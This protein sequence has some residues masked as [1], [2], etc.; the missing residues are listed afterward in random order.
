MTSTV[1]RSP[2]LPERVRSRIT[3]SGRRRYVRE[4]R[5]FA[6]TADR[7]RDLLVDLLRYLKS[8]GHTIG[9]LGASTKGNTLLQ[10]CGLGP[11]LIEGIGEVNPNKVGRDTPGSNIPIVDE[12]EVLGCDY[13]LVLP[14]HF[15]SSFM[16][17]YAGYL[18][19]GGRL[20]FPLPDITTEVA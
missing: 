16:E 7:H 19:H 11:D 17:R 2:S 5:S 14:W 9:A 3:G 13:L 6:A 10:F 15:K 18:A 4:L 20:I 12:S 8:Q 1:A